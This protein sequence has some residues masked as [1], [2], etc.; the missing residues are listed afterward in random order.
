ML[1]H[2]MMT[3][4]SRVIVITP[5]G[6]NEALKIPYLPIELY[7]W[8]WRCLSLCWVHQSEPFRHL[9]KKM[10]TYHTQPTAKTF[11][12]FGETTRL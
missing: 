1:Q 12:E 6:N 7:H 9:N 10:L 11:G 4:Y 3:T 5:A 8:R 2:L